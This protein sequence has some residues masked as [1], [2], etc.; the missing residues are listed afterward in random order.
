MTVRRLF[1]VALLVSGALVGAP[2]RAV[3]GGTEGPDPY[4]GL[5]AWVDVFD[6]VPAY[7]GSATLTT[8]DDLDVYASHGVRTI[9][10]QVA[11]ADPRSEGLLASPRR[12]AAFLRR[13]HALD[14][15]VVAWYLPLFGR[16]SADIARVDAMVEF[17]TRDGQRF[18]SVA[19]DIED[20]TH[21]P[22]VNNRNRRLLT[23]TRHLDDVMPRRP[24]G[25]IVFPA[26]ALEVVHP[27]VWPRFPY[28]RM[29]PYVDVWLPMS[30]S[31]YRDVNSEYR[32][33]AFYARQNIARLRAHLPNAS[34][35]VIGGAAAGYSRRDTRRFVLA[36]RDEA[37]VGWS[38]YDAATTS[39]PSWLAL[40][41]NSRR[42]TAG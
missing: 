28:G 26:V 35:H 32:D 23:L 31:T 25:A 36:V 13:A 10:L 30:Y 11:K 33:P 2:T 21:V 27:G 15:T 18:D 9:Y 24:V 6:Y 14:M 19:L 41:Y 29:G 22:D 17:R 39:G 40:E 16:L 7:A 42:P 4:A 20:T 5:G 8:V 34:V 1:A 3:A 38:L 37:A 12:S